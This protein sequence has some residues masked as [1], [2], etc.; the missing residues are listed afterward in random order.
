LSNKQ[1][2]KWGKN[3]QQKEGKNWESHSKEPIT[4]INGKRIWNHLVEK[5]ITK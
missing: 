2:H 3:K 5:T 1:K 4:T